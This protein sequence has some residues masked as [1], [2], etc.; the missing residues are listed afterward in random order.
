MS[1]LK[2]NNVLVPIDF[3]DVSFTA[4]APALEFVED[5]SHLHVIH[6]LL[7]LSV[8]D[9]GAIWQTV[10]PESRQHHAESVLKDKLNQLGYSNLSIKVSIGVPSHEI[11]D[12]AQE[13]KIELI[14]M[15]THGSTGVKRVLMGSVA[16]QVVR[17]SPCPVLLLR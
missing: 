9:P 10:T 1:W 4:L 14:V 5:M 3:S 15:P 12:Y 7:P 8:V 16:E 13:N 17:L 2:K 11:V 6:V